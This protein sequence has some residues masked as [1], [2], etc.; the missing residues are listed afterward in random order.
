MELVLKI[1]LMNF[2]FAVTLSLFIRFYRYVRGLNEYSFS[3]PKIRKSVMSEEAGII[4][5][6]R[7]R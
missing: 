3:F 7:M 1:R 4:Y 2:K 6:Y 5:N